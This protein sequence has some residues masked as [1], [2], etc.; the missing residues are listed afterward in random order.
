MLILSRRVEQQ[1]LFPNLGVKLSILQV[2]GRVVKVGIEAPPEIKVLRQEVLS[3][4]RPP[5][6]AAS[7]SEGS[8]DLIVREHRWRNQ[9]NLLQLRLDAI[10][11]RIDIGQLSNAES[12]LASLVASLDSE[13]R[14]AS[15]SM[16]SSPES[17]TSER[18]I[19][20]LLAED[21]DNER[22]LMTY[23]LASHGFVVHVARDGAEACE[24]LQQW[25]T[26]PD[27]VLM[28]MHMP[29][30]NGLEALR[31]IRE[32]E[33]LRSLRVYAVTGSRRAVEEEP[34][35]HSW[36]RWFSKPLDMRLLVEAIRTDH[37][38]TNSGAISLSGGPTCQVL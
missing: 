23:L 4:A 3:Q 22:G 29:L 36:D 30:Y 13:N 16:V 32:D 1:I 34:I 26:L 24:Q 12:M 2:R 35:S 37:A 21:S 6:A 27:V 18:P 9:M 14:T 20:I 25:G 7:A 19:R 28:D 11:H 10:Q 31:R 8:A 5:L 17:T 33:R 15:R 38:S